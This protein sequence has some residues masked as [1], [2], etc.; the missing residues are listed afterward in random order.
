MFPVALSTFS[1]SHNS[2]QGLPTDH[3]VLQYV[4]QY[5]GYVQG[6]DFLVALTESGDNP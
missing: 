5:Y 1:V 3:L 2:G 6:Q 4:V